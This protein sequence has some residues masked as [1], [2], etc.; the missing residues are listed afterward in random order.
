MDYTVYINF[1]TCEEI[2]CNLRKITPYE[3]ALIMEKREA[4]GGTL[5]PYSL[6]SVGGIRQDI[7]RQYICENRLSFEQPQYEQCLPASAIRYY[8]SVQMQEFASS[9]H[10]LEKHVFQSHP[11]NKSAKL[12]EIIQRWVGTK[13]MQL[14]MMFTQQPVTMRSMQSY[15]LTYRSYFMDECKQMLYHMKVTTENEMLEEERQRLQ[16]KAQFE[17]QIHQVKAH[18]KRRIE[19]ERKRRSQTHEVSLQLQHKEQFEKQVHQIKAH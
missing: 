12:Q 13:F 17:E 14:Q 10:Q 11:A 2:W 5:T 7:I 3:A 16:Q 4:E 8:L 1:S 18:R 19:E 6:W 9:V 15:Y